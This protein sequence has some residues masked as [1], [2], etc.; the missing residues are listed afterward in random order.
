M[1]KTK[2][3]GPRLMYLGRV[4][5]FA[6]LLGIFLPG[7]VSAKDTELA[8]K[9]YELDEL[10]RRTVENHPLIGAAQADESVFMAKLFRAEWAWIP[11]GSFDTLLAPMPGQSDAGTNYDEWGYF[12]RSELK[13][14]MPIYTF[15]KWDA[16]KAMGRAGVSVAQAR[17][18]IAENVVKRSVYG[19]YTALL[20][21]RNALSVIDEGKSHLDR[22]Q[23]RLEVM[24][25]DDVD[26]YDPTDKLRLKIVRAEVT[27]REVDARSLVKTMEEVLRKLAG[28][29]ADD[30]V[31]L[32]ETKLVVPTQGVPAVQRCVEL[33]WDNRPEMRAL[34]AGVQ[35][36]RAAHGLA[37]A[38]WYPDLAIV[39][40]QIVADAPNIVDQGSAFVYDPYNYI[41]GGGGLA[42]K[43]DMD[44]IG[45]I[46]DV[47]EAAAQVRK[48]EAQ[49]GAVKMGIELEVK[50]LHLQY[51]D[52]QDRVDVA[53]GAFRAARGWLTA[54]ADLFDAG[55][56]EYGA[57]SD[58]V[59][60]YY[61]RKIKELE[62]RYRSLQA[63]ADVSLALGLD[64]PE[65]DRAT[66]GAGLEDAGSQETTKSE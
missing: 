61:T 17:T 59:R 40:R 56:V 20:F 31:K 55:L 45:R 66:L 50:K 54:K 18:K 62:A 4:M 43:W 58:A 30:P 38:K 37:E 6:C 23:R 27:D 48:M 41:G 8:P 12:S 7:S 35:A 46:S 16:L 51:T 10:V 39:G 14:G 22:A 15:G 60:A 53:K 11:R 42:L 32:A 36:R 65:L 21:A 25:E 57:V 63:K 47:D 19:A 1:N 49:R 13:V 64:L 3:S 26:G 34:N 5:F 2:N 33:A 29:E 28:L 44:V 9:G 52:Q 24:E